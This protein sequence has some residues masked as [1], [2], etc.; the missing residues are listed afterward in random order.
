MATKHFEI[1]AFTT[2]TSSVIKGNY[3]ESKRQ[4]DRAGVRRKKKPFENYVV[5]VDEKDTRKMAGKRSV[6]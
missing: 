4:R 5:S 2:G 6:I 1:S 3:R